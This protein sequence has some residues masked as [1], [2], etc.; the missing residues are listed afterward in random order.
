MLEIKILKCLN[1]AWISFIISTI[2]YQEVSCKY[3]HIFCR[4]ENIKKILIDAHTKTE[5]RIYWYPRK[6]TNLL[7]FLQGVC[8]KTACGCTTDQNHSIR[9][10][11][12][13][14]S[15]WCPFAI[16]WPN[17]G[18]GGASVL[19]GP[20][21]WQMSIIF[22]VLWFR[23]LLSSAF[24][25]YTANIIGGDRLSANLNCSLSKCI[26]DY[27]ASLIKCLW[28]LSSVTSAR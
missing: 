16:G 3:I 1:V 15:H 9:R 4:L 18:L 10:V 12:H 6:W 14:I 13:W 11:S 22:V 2:L 17:W 24:L 27:I 28:H 19:I 5:D 23:H 25:N 8:D 7:N 20:L 21:L 26:L